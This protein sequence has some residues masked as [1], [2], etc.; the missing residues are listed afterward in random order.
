MPSKIITALPIKYIWA[1]YLIST[2]TVTRFSF[3]PS[4]HR[5]MKRSL[6]KYNLY[7]PHDSSWYSIWNIKL[8]NPQPPSEQIIT[9][10]LHNIPRSLSHPVR[11]STNCPLL[12]TAT[13][14]WWWGLSLVVWVFWNIETTI[15]RRSHCPFAVQHKSPP[16]DAVDTAFRWCVPF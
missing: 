13:A 7:N 5:R 10:R 3:C 12:L 2:H 11:P 1:A 9:Y 14:S 16:L 8:P 6:S 15:L 4:R